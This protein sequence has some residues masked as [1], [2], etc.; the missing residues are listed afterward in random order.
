MSC[1][2]INP[3]AIYLFFY[4]YY[5][6]FPC[7]LLLLFFLFFFFFSFLSFFFLVLFLDVVYQTSDFTHCSEILI[8]GV[9]S[10][11]A[12]K[13]D[14]IKITVNVVAV[15]DEDDYNDNNNDCSRSSFV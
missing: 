7:L 8:C 6:F 11:F 1:R 3:L 12:T 15:N 14:A 9:F 5:R 13:P 4:C 10:E 2:T